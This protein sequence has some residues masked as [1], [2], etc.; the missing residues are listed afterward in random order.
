MAGIDFN[1][2]CRTLAQVHR[3]GRL[4]RCPVCGEVLRFGSRD[5][6]EGADYYHCPRD[7]EQVKWE[8]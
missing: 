4:P 7:G 8:W 5:R 2:G 1:A 3:A 6:V